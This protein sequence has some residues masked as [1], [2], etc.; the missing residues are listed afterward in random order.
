M[1]FFDFIEGGYYIYPAFSV[2]PCQNGLYYWHYPDYIWNVSL[3]NVTHF[4]EPKEVH[5]TLPERDAS[6]RRRFP[7]DDGAILMTPRHVAKRTI[8]REVVRRSRLYKQWFI[9]AQPDGPANDQCCYYN[10]VIKDA[11]W[12]E[13]YSYEQLSAGLVPEYMILDSVWS[14]RVERAKAATQT[15]AYAQSVS[16]YD[17]LTE[18]AEGAKTLS[19]LASPVKAAAALL[20]GLK[21]ANRSVWGRGWGLNY[22]QLKA[23]ARRLKKVT[24]KRT[25]GLALEKL[26]DGWLTL[27]YGIL[28]LTYSIQD[29]RREMYSSSFE[30]ARTQSTRVVNVDELAEPP[31]GVTGYLYWNVSGTIKVTTTVKQSYKK[32]ALQRVPDRVNFNAFRTAWELIPYSFVVDWFANVGDWITAHTSVD[33]SSQKKACTAVKT[34]LRR[35]ASYRDVTSDE[36]TISLWP[37]PCYPNGY[38]DSFTHQRDIDAVAMIVTE[39]LYD[40]DL[41]PGPPALPTLDPYL[42][43]QRKLSGI[44]LSLRPAKAALRRLRR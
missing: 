16:G 18:V 41:I 35:V 8:E 21:R 25:L 19:L 15:E 10:P 26:A 31:P 9:H 20:T 23:L 30:Y 11:A 22:R 5:E 43:W 29:I 14:S 37:H 6:Y 27:Q 42:S 17:A 2:G 1:A 44:A 7:P 24:S 13:S 38:Q 36:S 34:N 3:A 33:L 32:G 12:T 28:P 40:R 39:D 4:Y